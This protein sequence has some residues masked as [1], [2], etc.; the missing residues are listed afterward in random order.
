MQTFL[1]MAAY[2]ARNNMLFVASGSAKPNQN[3]MSNPI[4]IGE[5]RVNT[6]DVSEQVDG[7][8]AGPQAEIGDVPHPESY[9]ADLRSETTDTDNRVTTP[10][11][12]S[13]RLLPVQR[14]TTSRGTQTG[15]RNHIDIQYD[16]D[17]E[18]DRHVMP[19]FPIPMLD[20]LP[21]VNLAAPEVNEYGFGGEM[22]PE[23]F[24][25][26]MS[27]NDDLVAEYRRAVVTQPVDPTF[28]DFTLPELPAP[29][30][31]L[32]RQRADGGNEEALDFSLFE[33]P[34]QAA[35]DALDPF[36]GLYDHS[37][38]NCG[39]LYKMSEP[40]GDI[41]DI[42][43]SHL[44]NYMPTTQQA[45][46]QASLYKFY[47]D[48][49]DPLYAGDFRMP[50][51]QEWIDEDDFLH[52]DECTLERCICARRRGF[53]RPFD[54][55]LGYP[56]E[57]PSGGKPA[58]KTGS[59]PKN[60]KPGAKKNQNGKRSKPK[61][62]KC[63]HLKCRDGAN[64]IV[65]GHHHLK[66]KTGW[67]KREEEKNVKGGAAP[68]NPRGD[69]KNGVKKQCNIP[70]CRCG[71]DSE[72][73]HSTE[74]HKDSAATEAYWNNPVNQC[75][76]K[77]QRHTVREVE[78]EPEEEKR[79]PRVSA[80]EQAVDDMGL[81]DIFED[82][83]D[84][85]PVAPPLEA[86]TPPPSR[87]VAPAL[88]PTPSDPPKDDGK[89]SDEEEEEEQLPD[90][91]TL[92]FVKNPTKVIQ[93]GWRI[94][95]P[96]AP[97]EEPAWFCEGEEPSHHGRIPYTGPWAWQPPPAAAFIPKQDDW[98]T[99]VGN[100]PDSKWTAPIHMILPPSML[101]DVQPVLP[102][103]KGE[104]ITSTEERTDDFEE[105]LRVGYQRAKELPTTTVRLFFRG[106]CASH[107][108][109]GGKL[110]AAA[111]FAMGPFSKKNTATVGFN[112]P[113][114]GLDT[115]DLWLSTT[116]NFTKTTDT[117]YAWNFG[118]TVADGLKHWYK[119]ETNVYLQAFE[120]MFTLTREAVIF[121]YMAK[122]MLVD[123]S[124]GKKSYVDAGG[125]FMDYDSLIKSA[126]SKYYGKKNPYVHLQQIY[127]DTITFVANQ[128][129][130]RA[131]ES[132]MAKPENS[133]LAVYF[134]NGQRL[135]YQRAA[136][137]PA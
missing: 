64:C 116:R 103:D 46:E 76:V 104:K 62:A 15:P 10:H 75:D 17:I 130:L 63:T 110:A 129:T 57:G 13:S 34:L 92:S 112:D 122:R 77:P 30:P 61:G 135:R 1:F 37:I 118:T 120:K 90:Y 71:D 38:Y 54:S 58:P 93:G 82:E 52:E 23:P 73:F 137:S 125:N 94:N 89:Y 108:T 87:V 102:L 69:D 18:D 121:P 53:K 95:P 78:E 9:S 85:P 55:T 81:D 39:P 31:P 60:G 65:V 79:E 88:E 97:E 5:V 126:M 70:A 44:Y 136:S 84:L 26:G 101:K 127:Q 113:G 49:F 128:L 43:V 105:D 72:H 29:P 68:S 51:L 119:G 80:A 32:K 107:T 35:P 4:P 91:D 56:G 111:N 99:I 45:E 14:R 114:I 40:L 22:S 132:D 25:C 59:K 115:T 83:P 24:P 50:D 7:E 86:P 27:F 12:S 36:E 123:E 98:D 106:D 109:L 66:P 131:I 19:A 16:F 47:T 117:A 48:Y 3:I 33:A 6:P 42:D 96:S 28:I 100:K 21:N 11:S 124:V 20:E 133:K 67:S 41:E 134:R 8:G 74:E 2:Q